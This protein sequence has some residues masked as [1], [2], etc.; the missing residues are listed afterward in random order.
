[1]LEQVLARRTAA[2]EA[3]RYTL[4]EAPQTDADLRAAEAAAEAEAAEAVASASKAAAPWAE[5][6]PKDFIKV[7]QEIDEKD[8][9]IEEVRV[10]SSLRWCHKC[11]SRSYMRQGLCT[12]ML[13]PLFFNGCGRCTTAYLCKG[14]ST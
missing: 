7:K 11:Q 2:E 1:L 13:C 14:A 3:K 8:L 9:E 6:A 4:Q 10:L 5:D 12:N